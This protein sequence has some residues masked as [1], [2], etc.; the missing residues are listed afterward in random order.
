MNKPFIIVIVGVIV[1]VIATLTLTLSLLLAPTGCC[2]IRLNPAL[3]DRYV[4]CTLTGWDAVEQ[5]KPVEPDPAGRFLLQRGSTCQVGA[6]TPIA[7]LG[8]EI[9]NYLWDKTSARISRQRCT[10]LVSDINAACQ[11]SSQTGGAFDCRQ[12]QQD[13]DEQRH[14]HILSSFSFVDDCEYPRADGGI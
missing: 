2:T 9:Y 1:L 3:A 10:S 4:L 12:A 13:E 8:R 6:P 7:A 11:A 14:I 5:D